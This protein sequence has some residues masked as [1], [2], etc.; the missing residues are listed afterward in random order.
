[1]AS[2]RA[3]ID[4]VGRLAAT[5]DRRFMVRLVKGAYWDTE[6]KR[7]QERGLA[8]YPV[9]TRKPMTDLSYMACAER[10]LALR[11]RI[12]PTIRDAQRIDRGE[13]DRDGRRHRGLRVP[14]PARHGRGAVRRAAGGASRR[15]LRTYA[16][17]G[18]IATCSP[19][20]CAACWRTAPIPP[21][22]RWRPMRACL[23]KRC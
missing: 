21:S 20:W 16:P 12:Y 15:R 11:P 7:A 2:A 4:W 19:I 9:F 8:D 13:C 6:I 14:A 17:V 18:G 22:C 10:L 23:S 1:M 5:L 3:V